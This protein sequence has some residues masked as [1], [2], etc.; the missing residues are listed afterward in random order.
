MNQAP[1]KLGKK[2]SKEILFSVSHQQIY[3]K[4][5][6]IIDAY[7]NYTYEEDYQIIISR[8]KENDN[9]WSQGA[10]KIE[11]IYL[12]EDISI[13]HGAHIYAGPNSK[14]NI[15]SGTMIG[16]YVF[17]TTEAFSKSKNNPQGVHSGHMG[18]IH[19]GSNVRIGA[20]STILPGAQIGSGASIGA[21]SVVLNSVPK[22]SIFAGNPAKMIKEIK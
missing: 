13:G 22:N 15:D 9:A 16:P 20:H 1:F 14:V 12:N 4:G 2:E 6:A 18:D 8:F 19:I 21:G 5:T 17:I 10:K 7:L 3:S 11:N